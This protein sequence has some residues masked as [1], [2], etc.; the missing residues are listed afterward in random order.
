[1]HKHK[2]GDTFDM[3]VVATVDDVARDMT[4]WSGISEIRTPAGVLIETLTFTWLDA[5]AG[6][7]R[8]YSV[9]DT[10]A[11][12]LGNAYWDIQFTTPTG[13]VISSPT[14]T[15]KVIADVSQ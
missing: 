14:V 7:F 12:P 9:D 13:Q 6:L 10:Q 1:M 2:Q 8:I 11:W 4:S 15:V 5:A 3:S